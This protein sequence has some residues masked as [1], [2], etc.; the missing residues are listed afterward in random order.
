MPRGNRTERR[1]RGAP[2][3]RLVIEASEGR[4]LRALLM[5]RHG[6]T[7]A[8]AVAGLLSGELATVLLGDERRRALLQYVAGGMAEAPPAA[9][10]IALRDVAQQLQA[11]EE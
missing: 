4:A 8:E 3:G 9:A 7:A 5:E 10:A 11:I 1:G 2:P 6:Y